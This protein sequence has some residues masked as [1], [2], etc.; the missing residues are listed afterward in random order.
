[1]SAEAFVRIV[2][3]AVYIPVCLIAY[4]WL[5]PRLSPTSKAVAVIML[6]LQIVVIALCLELQKTSTFVSV[7][8]Q[9]AHEWNVPSTLASTQLAMVAGLALLTA[10]LA[11]A[12]PTTHRLYFLFV[13]LLF[14]YLTWDE[15]YIIHEVMPDWSSKYAALGA[16]VV[17][18]TIFIAAR[19]P[20]RA[21][22]WHLCFLTGLALS[23]F[24]AL[25]LEGKP[26]P[27]DSLAFFQFDGCIRLYEWE[28]TL[29]FLGIWL[30]LV[31]TL[32]AFTD[33]APA[34]GP[35]LRLVV[36][37]IPVLWVL[38]LFVNALLPRV[39]LSLLAKPAKVEFDNGVTLQ[40][41]RIDNTAGASRVHLYVSAKQEDY[42]FAGWSIHLVDQVS[43]K[44]IAHQNLD[45]DRRHTIWLFGPDYESMYRQDM[46]VTIPADTPT[47]RAMW[48]V[49]THW[50]RHSSDFPPQIVLSS[51]MQLLVD[52][53]VILG[54]MVLPAESA[55]SDAVPLA[56]FD[57]GFA[58]V[59][60]D[61][62]EH[63]QSGATLEISFTWRSDTAGTEDHA[64]YLHLG[65]E[66]SGNGGSMTKGRWERDCQPALGI[67][68]WLKVKSGRCHCPQI[69]RPGATMS[70]QV[71]IGRATENGFRSAI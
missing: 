25:F 28:E 16:A 57:N 37:A 26:V 12:R 54:E 43:G 27:C 47:N 31:A 10:W 21:R 24:G 41:Y 9:L 62:P 63:A 23:A 19:S 2:I 51:D 14:L 22:L 64:Q 15:Y 7:T 55:A 61:L 68:A 65:H 44:S 20:A 30:V 48:I 52:N 13:G 29:E 46:H 70:S 4:W 50:R 6:A 40:G 56:L 11:K 34:P 67:M 33:V 3:I 36:Y 53:Q 58:L 59:A 32:G 69:W 42:F 38:V 1:M 35:H 5:L 39:E 60:A 49:L 8:W 45:A 17:A 71:C 66:E 18:I